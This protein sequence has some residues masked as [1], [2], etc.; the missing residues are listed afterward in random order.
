MEKME[1]LINGEDLNSYFYKKTKIK[2]IN[3]CE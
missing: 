3:A 1:I 2:I